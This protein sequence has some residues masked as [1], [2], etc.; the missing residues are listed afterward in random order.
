MLYILT[1]FP[2][3]L[4]R[5]LNSLWLTESFR[6][7][8][9]AHSNNRL[10]E[11]R[12]NEGFAGLVFKFLISHRSYCIFQNFSSLSI[13]DKCKI[14]ELDI[15]L[16]TEADRKSKGV[17]SCLVLFRILASYFS[18]P[19]SIMAD[20][21]FLQRL[22]ITFLSFYFITVGMCVKNCTPQQRSTVS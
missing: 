22:A 21:W 15:P 10:T 16:L 5:N 11:V 2:T 19:T 13:K 18:A 9:C 1:I 4:L 17:N 3:V 14:K 8:L 7:Q 20:I 6:Q 12:I